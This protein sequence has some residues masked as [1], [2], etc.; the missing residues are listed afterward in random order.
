[1]GGNN[2]SALKKLQ[3]IIAINS[4]GNQQKRRN[5]YADTQKIFTF[6]GKELSKQR[7]GI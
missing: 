7:G 3:F 6:C 2:L 5:I 4:E 1:V